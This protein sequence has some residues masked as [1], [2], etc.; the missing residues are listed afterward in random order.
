M[1]DIYLRHCDAGGK[2]L[3]VTLY[4]LGLMLALL[5]FAASPVRAENEKTPTGNAQA[6]RDRDEATRK[7][8]IRLLKNSLDK[9]AVPRREIW[10]FNDLPE[11]R[12]RSRLQESW[13]DQFGSGNAPF[14]FVAGPAPLHP[15]TVNRYA[16]RVVRIT[17]K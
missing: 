6:Q 11:S 4:A 16:V 8:I 2:K 10:L 7:E 15:G 1:L 9:A 17:I 5:T 3:R 13:N 14:S 12:V